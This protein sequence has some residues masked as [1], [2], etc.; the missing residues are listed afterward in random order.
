MDLKHSDD[1]TLSRIITV[2]ENNMEG[3]QELLC[4]IH[5]DTNIPVIG[6]TGPPG[7]GKSTLIN[8]LIK[9]ILKDESKYLKG[10]GI[11][12][13]AVDPS[14][15]FSQGA[16][17]G[18]RLRLSDHFQHPRVFIR[19]LASRGWLGGLSSATLE[20]TDLLREAGF[21]F[22]F[23]ETVGV[24]QSETEIVSLADLT[25]VVLVPESGD[26][27]QALKAG[28]AEI[29]DVFVVNKNDREGADQLARYIEN[30]AMLRSERKIKVVSTNALKGEGTDLLLEALLDPQN[31]PGES[32]RKKLL[33]E[34][35]IRLISDSRMKKIPINEIR[36]KLE[37]QWNKKDFNLYAFVKQFTG[38]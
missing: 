32:K 16:L 5:P 1:K 6:F 35:C 4:S 29:A 37:E 34:K 17:L 26:E 38:Q 33:Y 12:V 20:I 25:V 14:S 21:D 31:Q 24:G 30:A 9:E 36:E 18:D 10:R 2:V 27:V 11:A 19:S 8:A 23:V 13:L 15:P 3:A 7:A 28:L 22:I